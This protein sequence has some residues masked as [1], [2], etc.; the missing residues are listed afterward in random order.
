MTNKK[1]M[2]ISTTDNMVWQFLIPHI[3]H[4]ESLGNTVECVCA[5]TGFWFDE[6]KDKYN[7]VMHEIDFARNP[8]TLKN[9]KSYKKITN[10]I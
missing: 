3:M 10:T 7:L 2:M 8:I 5:R 9:L 4:L 1:I 6:L